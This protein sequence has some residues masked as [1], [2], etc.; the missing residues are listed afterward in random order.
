MRTSPLLKNGIALSPAR[1][2]T[3]LTDGL[4]AS[5][6]GID[7]PRLAYAFHGISAVQPQERR[8]VPPSELF[9]VGRRQ[10]DAVEKGAAFGIRR[11][12]VVDREHD[13]IDAEGLQRRQE[14]RRSE[15]AAG[16]DP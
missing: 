12:G 6:P 3:A 16:G 10:R 2:R 1:A 8:R 13:A 7:K 11:I 9:H 4:S 15:D 14:R 5:S